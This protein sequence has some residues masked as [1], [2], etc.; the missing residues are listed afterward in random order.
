MARQ[1][2]AQARQ[3]STHSCISPTA[4]QSSAQRLH[5]SAQTPQVRRCKGESRSMKFAEV[6]QISAQSIM[7]RK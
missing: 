7:R 2:W 5:T 1:E 6:A 4:A 3:A